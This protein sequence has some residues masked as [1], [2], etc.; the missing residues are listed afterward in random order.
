MRS[1]CENYLLVGF[2]Y[3]R[4]PPERDRE[5]MDGIEWEAGADL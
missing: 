4:E 3:D 5:G 2:E 1:V